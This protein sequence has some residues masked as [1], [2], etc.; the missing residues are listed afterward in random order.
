MSK[1]KKNK[2]HEPI[3]IAQARLLF[4][5]IA[6]LP[7]AL[8]LFLLHPLAGLFGLVVTG[9]CF[10]HGYRTEKD[11]QSRARLAVE[12]M[13][14][15]FEEITKN[16][17]F[18]MPFPMA[19]FNESG[20][21]LWYNS[22]FKEIFKINSSALGQPV[23]SVMGEIS[24]ELLE[25]QKGPIE[26]TVGERQLAFY[27]N[28]SSDDPEDCLFLLYGVDKSREEELARL[29]A[30]NQMVVCSLFFDNYDEVRSKLAE[31][32]RPLLTAQI[33]RMINAF[34]HHYQA[35]CIKYESERY[36]LLTTQAQLDQMKQDHFHLLEEIKTVEGTSIAP[37][38]SMGIAYGA[39][40]PLELW[41]ESRQAMDI[42]LSRGGDQAVLKS[43]DDLSYVGGK[44]QATQHF[45]KVKARVMSNT[46]RSFVMNSD[47]VFVMGHDNP[48]MD[49]LG[50]CLGMVAFVQSAGVE[51]H[52]VLNEV[53][54]AIEN[55]YQ[56]V[57]K[58]L[59]GAKRLFLNSEEAL[60]RRTAASLVVVVDNHR[61][62]SAAAP[63]LLDEGNRIIIIDHHR[64][65]QDYIKNAEISYIEP[66]ASSAS[67]MVTELISYLDNRP[68]L[69]TVVAEALLAGI[70]VDT[71]GFYYQTGTRTFEAAAYLK[72]QGA[73]SIVIKQ[74]FQDDFTLTRYRAEIL[75]RAQQ[76]EHEIMISRFEH[77][78]EG[79]TL[80]AS[81]AADELLGIRGVKASFVLCYADDRIHISARSFGDISV[82]LIM[83]A[84]GGG[85]H[86]TASATQLDGTMDQAEEQLKTAIHHYFEE[87]EANESHTA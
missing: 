44:N 49:S 14:A 80:V 16:A 50:T 32:D 17:I 31:A 39:F 76:F 60:D 23:T 21:F 46:I 28:K 7:L 10:V 25:D 62:D 8:L 87:E 73:D 15:N 42:A 77:E 18:R 85:G 63:A 53:T 47:Q 51:A 27:H 83:E 72:Q 20:Q 71:K 75:A 6:C 26:L 41:N 38:L 86:L 24:P 2:N 22:L 68:N 70:T 64:R 81:Q 4:S 66:Y 29:Y 48:D 36:A 3:K 67:E 12:Q 40:T 54:P 65:G 59:P 56:K 84:L 35:V 37:T 13:D 5:P 74:L 79:S 45:T 61:H 34:A 1:Q 57:M 9:A 55:L 43:G 11:A 78:V 52:I 82:Q 30:D 19:V 58:D 69:P 33:D